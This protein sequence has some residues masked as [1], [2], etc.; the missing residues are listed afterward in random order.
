MIANVYKKKKQGKGLLRSGKQRQSEL[1]V[2]DISRA[3]EII[4]P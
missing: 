4:Q 3:A 2:G 1:V